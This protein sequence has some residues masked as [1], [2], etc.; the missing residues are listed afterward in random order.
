MNLVERIENLITRLDE[1]DTRSKN[2]D[3]VQ[4]LKEGISSEEKALYDLEVKFDAVLE[5]VIALESIDIDS[6]RIGKEDDEKEQTFGKELKGS[7]NPSSPELMTISLNDLGESDNESVT[8]FLSPKASPMNRMPGAP[9]H[10]PKSFNFAIPAI[11]EAEEHREEESP[12]P[13][14]SPSLNANSPISAT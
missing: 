11:K 13:S 8:D 2:T 10:A 6:L 1:V 9:T 4:E 7:L 14:R 3:V 5:R 12:I